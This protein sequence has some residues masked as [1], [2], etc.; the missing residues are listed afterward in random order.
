LRTSTRV[1]S[2]RYAGRVP[3]LYVLRHAKSS[4]DD[5]SLP[6]HDRPLAPRG[7][8]NAGQMADHLRQVDPSP[9]LVVCSGAL[10][11]RQTL[12][13]VAPA[14]GDADMLIEDQLYGAWAEALM[15]RIR[16]IPDRISSALVIGHNP[17]MQEL[18]L[19]LSQPGA[20]RDRAAAKFPTCALAA[21][22][23]AGPWAATADGGGV[24]DELTVLR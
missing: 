13:L 14:L 20:E 4:W 19:R 17:G 23:L 15:A 7:I 16:R 12:D 8:R 11:T 2:D 18:V 6:D 3:T 22:R 24:L 5:D 10:R 9:A 21:I 1:R